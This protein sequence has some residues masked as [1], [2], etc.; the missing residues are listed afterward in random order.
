MNKLISYLSQSNIVGKIVHTL[1]YCLKSELVDCQT[2]LD[3]GCGPSSPIQFCKNIKYSVGVEIFPQY[4]S[5]SKKRH[6][7]TK[8]LDKDFLKLK[9]AKNSFDAVI[10]IEVLEHLDKKDGLEIIKRASMWAKKKIIIS[11]PNGYFPMDEVDQN[12]Y[13]KHRSGWN[14]SELSKL[15]FKVRGV[16]GLKLFY[17]SHNEIDSLITGSNYTNIRFYPKPFFYYLN[18]LMQILSYY[19]PKY[20]FGLFA[21]KKL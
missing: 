16:S 14:V 20:S 11:T 5:E 21:I 15:K 12:L 10:M 2:V 17:N 3:L 9:F 7:H 19:L 18:G 13:Q 1:N 6:I 8:Y 4:L